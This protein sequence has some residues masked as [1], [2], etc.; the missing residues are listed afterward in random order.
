MGL[1]F[2]DLEQDRGPAILRWMVRRD[3]PGVLAIEN[4]RL[5]H[6]WC[7]AN[8]IRALRRRNC[9]GMVADYDGHIEGFAIYEIHRQRIEI[10]RLAVHPYA[11]R[12][13][14]GRSMV[15]KLARKL[16]PVRRTRLALNVRET[17]LP[18]QFFLRAVGFR[19]VNVIR[20]HYRDTG[21]DAYRMERPVR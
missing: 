13:G 18:A 9:I 5:D 12:E 8:V 10:V 21:E 7:G 15:E 2:T 4:S 19:A 14:L 1:M 6:P 17:N 20:G 3:I 11:R 16:D